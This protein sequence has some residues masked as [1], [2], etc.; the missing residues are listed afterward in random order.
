MNKIAP[1]KLERFFAQYEFTTEI[2]LSCSDCES[3]TQNEVLEMA[4]PSSKFLWDNLSLGYTESQGH[5]QLRD[6]IKK[7]YKNISSR[8]IM[9]LAPEEGIYIA[10]QTMLHPGDHIISI[11]PTY[12]S[13]SEI[14]TSIG[15]QLSFWNIDVQNQS[16]TLDLDKLQSLIKPH[17]R[18]LIL[19]F[20][21]NPT[22]FLPDTILLEKII[23]IA[24][25]NDLYIFSDEMYHFLELKT[26]KP[27]PLIADY[28]EKGISLSGVS[29]SMALPGLR[30]GWLAS[31]D[32][33]LFQKWVV[34]KDYT[35]ICCSAP[36]EI[37]ALIAIKNREQ[38]V[39][40][41][42]EII[43]SNLAISENFFSQYP[44]LFNWLPPMA[45]SIAF[46]ELKM[47]PVDTFCKNLVDTKNT[48]LA[49]G[50]LFGHVGNHF[51]LGL[52]RRNF[53]KG[54]E[55][56]DEFCQMFY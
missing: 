52:G 44:E 13:L 34:Y 47:H 49:P 56:L 53:P 17:T 45:G 1:F 16:W 38:I 41:N 55:R 32:K 28:Y 48:L 6:E 11:A 39:T 21:H 35:T 9:V 4:D 5:P 12:Q 19:N 31:Q 20:P 22:G 26:T 10:M 29:K 40:R 50:H 8:Q 7:M 37:L 27:L 15:C 2:L 30:M 54:I 43:H 23:H 24:R 25:A 51:R 18:L 14:A 33:E 3:L 36:S 42:K 46:P